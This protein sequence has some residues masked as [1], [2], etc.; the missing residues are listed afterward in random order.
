VLDLITCRN[1]LI[2][3]SSPLQERLLP[4]FH[5]ALNPG[6]FLVLGAAESVG[7]SSDLFELVSRPHKIYRRKEHGRRQPLA[8]PRRRM[9]ERRRRAVR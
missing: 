6:G 1:V 4:T 3:M 2:Y 5:F 9:A 8:F 7:S